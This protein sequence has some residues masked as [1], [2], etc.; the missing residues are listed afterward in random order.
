MLIINLNSNRMIFYFIERVAG[1]HYDCSVKLVAFILVVSDV[2]AA[3]TV[4][5]TLEFDI[6][7][8]N[9]FE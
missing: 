7:I 1:N 8:C 3:I 5:V 9:F 2:Y 4:T 6:C